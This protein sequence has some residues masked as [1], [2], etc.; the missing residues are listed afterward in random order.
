VATIYWKS[1][2]EIEEEQNLPNPPTTEERIDT[3]ENVILQLMME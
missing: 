1:K 2:E 3:L